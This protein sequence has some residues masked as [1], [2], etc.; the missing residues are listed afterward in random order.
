MLR[1]R[2]LTVARSVYRSTASFQIP[3]PLRNAAVDMPSP[4][5]PDLPHP[6]HIEKDSALGRK[7]GKEVVNYFGSMLHRCPFQT[8]A[9]QSRLAAE[10]TFL[11]A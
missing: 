3:R 6:A 9:Y 8:L 10:Q 1:N 11:P 4:P 2:F 5:Q 7:F